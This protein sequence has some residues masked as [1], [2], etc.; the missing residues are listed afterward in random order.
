MRS[1]DHSIF[2]AREDGLARSAVA[3]VDMLADME[4]QSNALCVVPAER[5]VA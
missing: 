4:E 2:A 5:L 1:T 3:A